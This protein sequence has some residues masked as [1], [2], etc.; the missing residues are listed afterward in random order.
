M[1]NWVLYIVLG[2]HTEISDTILKVIA[3]NALNI[4]VSDNLQIE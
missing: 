1:D 4:I 2:F 3:Y